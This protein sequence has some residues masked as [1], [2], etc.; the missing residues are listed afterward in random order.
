MQENL[1]LN[2]NRN[3]PSF[4]LGN[5]GKNMKREENKFSDEK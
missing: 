1:M 4:R 3:Y 5:Y 2:T